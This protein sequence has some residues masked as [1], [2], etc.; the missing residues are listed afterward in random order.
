M[1]KPDANPVETLTTLP[2][3]TVA[4]TYITSDRT[5]P[6]I[7]KTS[8][9][10]IHT[11]HRNLHSNETHA[12]LRITD[13]PQRINTSF[14][15]LVKHPSITK[16]VITLT[17]HTPDG[18]SVT[19]RDREHA[20]T[21]LLETN[22]EFKQQYNQFKQTHS[23]EPESLFKKLLGK[24]RLTAQPQ[25]EPAFEDL[26][27]KLQEQIN[28]E[29]AKQPATPHSTGTVFNTYIDVVTQDTEN[30]V[31]TTKTRL[32]ELGVETMRATHAPITS[33]HITKHGLQELL[34]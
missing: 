16:L 14:T 27:E 13:A 8:T 29:A 12:H 11:H 18:Y 6:R 21:T 33:I 20:T 24:L 25:T 7:D 22:P 31:Q 19:D 30:D 26:P 2:E 15:E 10:D 3:N 23:K 1:K 34:Q 5:T 17:Q 9:S 32:K 28:A 4:T